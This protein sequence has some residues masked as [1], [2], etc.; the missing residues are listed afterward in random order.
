MVLNCGNDVRDCS[1]NEGV[2]MDKH[3]ATNGN[4]RHTTSIGISGPIYGDTM[5][6]TH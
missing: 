4:Q 6:V 1:S 3:H 2:A 5:S